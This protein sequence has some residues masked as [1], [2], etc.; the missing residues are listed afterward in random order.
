MTHKNKSA[1]PLRRR[2]PAN[3]SA[4]EFRTAGHQLVDTIAE[5]FESLP[6]RPVTRAETPA[7][8]RTIL[9]SMLDENKLPETGKPA[10]ELLNET[11]ELLFDHSLH[12]GHPRFFGYITSSATPLGALA[13]MLAASINNNLGK[14]DLSPLA[15]EIEAQ[16][17]RWIAELIGYPTNCGGIMSSGGNMANFLAFVAAR[18]AQADWPIREHGLQGNSRQ[19]TVYGS[20]E[21]HTWIEKATD[22]TGLGTDAIRWID[23]DAEQRMCIDALEAQ[24]DADI[25]DGCTPF[26]VVGTAGNVSTGAIDPLAA[27][28]DIC[29]RRGLWFHVDGAYGA[30]AAALP[31]ASDDLR[32]LARA[33]S[34]ALDPH[35]WL[36]NPIEAGCTLVRDPTALAAAFSFEP[37]YYRL[38][39]DE[40]EPGPN[41]YAMGMQNTRGFRA[42]KVWLNLRH[43]GRLGYV[44]MISQDIALAQRLY[45]IAQSHDELEAVAQH[46]SIT[47]LR[48]VPRD[49]SV[50]KETDANYLNDLNQ[51]ILDQ[52]QQGGEIFVSNAIIDSRYTLRA[53]VVNFRTTNDDI[54]ALPEIILR[55]GRQLDASI[56]PENLS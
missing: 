38:N 9:N 37:S 56:R 4:E 24:L 5:F 49:L 14:W 53:C 25:A 50:D 40:T 12:N 2:T 46:L 22:I 45:K 13:D 42:L 47:N 27:L 31:D 7:E 15:S 54:D 39:T 17:V 48:F 29:T 18:K 8:I 21:T 52:L 23:T 20:R 36:Y 44:D 10:N 30:P 3:L 32:A 41:Y 34:V 11:A 19:L 35:K 33:D 28:A 1:A 43:I 55:T 16:S 6:E 26:I 51:A